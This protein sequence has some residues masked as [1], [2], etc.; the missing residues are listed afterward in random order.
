MIIDSPKRV[1]CHEA[2]LDTGGLTHEAKQL[3]SLCY[4]LLRDRIRVT[5][6]ELRL[7]PRIGTLRGFAKSTKSKLVPRPNEPEQNWESHE[8]LIRKKRVTTLRQIKAAKA[9]TQIGRVI[10]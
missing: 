3:N 10:A 9:K 2:Q 7:D 4:P 5:A 1:G 8:R 6:Q